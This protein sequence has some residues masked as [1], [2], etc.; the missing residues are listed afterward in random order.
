[1]TDLALHGAKFPI[2]Y[3]FAQCRLNVI[4]DLGKAMTNG[5]HAHIS[6]ADLFNLGTPKYRGVPGDCPESPCLK[7]ALYSSR[8][9]GVG[10]FSQTGASTP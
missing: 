7:T 10:P 5:G 6:F 3:L 2:S 1:M 4:V 9:F 8:W